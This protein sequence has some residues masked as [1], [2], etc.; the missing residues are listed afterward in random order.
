MN[1]TA[2]VAAVATALAMATS[3]LSL[4]PIAHAAT[5]STNLMMGSSGADVSA[6]QQTLIASGYSI[7]A[8]ATGYFGAQTKA[9]VMAWQAAAGISP[10]AGYFGPI[11]RAKLSGAV[12][13]GTTSTVAGCAAG[14]M[15]SSTTGQ[16]CGSMTTTTTT[17]GA[18]TGAGRLTNI[19]SYGSVYT[20]LKEADAATA[21]VGVQADATSGDVAI[22]RVDATFYVDDVSSQ[23]SYLNQYV[24]DVSVYLNGTKL[25]SMDPSLGDKS[26]RV[27]TYRFSGLSGVIKQGTTGNIVVKVTPLTSIGATEDGKAVTAV[28]LAN[29]V[30]AIGADGISDTYLATSPTVVQNSGSA[31]TVSGGTIGG[32]RFTVSSATTGTLTVTAGAD[33]PTASQ[34]AVSSSTTTGVKLLSF[35]MKAKN[36]SVKV[37][38]L[39]ASIGT[40]GS[41]SSVVNTVYLMKGSQVLKST[42]LSSGTYQTVTFSNINDTI[43]KDSTNNYTIVADLKGDAAY[44]DG[45]TLIASTTVSGWD[46]SDTNGS[47]VTPSA[48]AVGNTQTLTATGITVTKG[49]PTAIVQTASFSNGVDTA[50]YAIPFTVQAGDND[51]YVSGVATN[52]TGSGAGIRYSTTTTS[53]QGATGQPTASVSVA[54]TVTGD[55]AGVYY[56]VLAGTSRTFTLNATLAASSTGVTAGYAGVQVNSIAYG[57]TTALGSSYTSNLDTFKTNDVYVTKH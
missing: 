36:A 9:A 38:D 23:S 31:D 39:V 13:T 34:V 14:A 25:A 45:T 11:S 16:A 3:M 32:Q 24:S 53:T 40:S 5:F 18:L 2:K 15:Y 37:T 42:T 33:N 19:S 49:T 57:L 17:G 51:V 54:N 41:L 26:G 47:S 52:G 1:A 35:N 43:S 30:R 4:A 8:G 48:A 22:Q 7:P 21:V 20:D 6:L 50:S 10:A 46:V 12:T 56:K 27:W 28:L 29:S 55:S 44:S